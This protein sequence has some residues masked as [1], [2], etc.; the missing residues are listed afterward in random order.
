MAPVSVKK[1]PWAPDCSVIGSYAK[2]IESGDRV[3]RIEGCTSGTLGFLLTEIGRGS[4][5]SA[6]L[7][8]AM[9]KGYTEP[10]P[11][12]DLS[13]MD[14]ARK[15]LILA[16][17]LVFNGELRA[18][19]VSSLVP[20]AQRSACRLPNTCRRWNHL[21]PIGKRARNSAR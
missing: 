17:M 20:P 3:V 19:A 18:V 7:R 4:L 2:L 1:R 5:L 11:R 9:E 6:A 10:D 12:D 16:R 14:V 8:C 15:A 13:G 21:T